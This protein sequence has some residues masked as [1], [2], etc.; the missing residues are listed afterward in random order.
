MST[1]FARHLK[2]TGY[3]HDLLTTLGETETGTRID[4]TAD[5]ILS[6]RATWVQS[7]DDLTI[8][9]DEDVARRADV[10]A[11]AKLA[12]IESGTIRI[13]RGSSQLFNPVVDREGATAAATFEAVHSVA[14]RDIDPDAAGRELARLLGRP[15]GLHLPGGNVLAKDGSLETPLPIE[16]IIGVWIASPGDRRVPGFTLPE[17]V[18]TQVKD[19][20]TVGELGEAVRPMLEDL[21]NVDRVVADLLE[22]SSDLPNLPVLLPGPDLGALAVIPR[23]ADGFTR[24]QKVATQVKAVIPDMRCTISQAWKRPA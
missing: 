11:A 6:L 4:F 7:N 5:K 14:Q 23:T 8:T 16:R 2:G 12:G 3:G 1:A 10:E 13:Q 15:I 19:V 9:I 22:M 17:N 24:A 21:A 18:V 20:E